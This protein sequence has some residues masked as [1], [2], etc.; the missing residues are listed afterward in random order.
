VIGQIGQ[1]AAFISQCRLTH[2]A[3]TAFAFQPVLPQSNQEHLPWR[4]V[5]THA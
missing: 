1:L 3:N 2:W 4:F 5:T